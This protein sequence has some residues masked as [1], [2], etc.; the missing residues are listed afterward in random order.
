LEH[1]FDLMTPAD[2]ILRRQCIVFLHTKLKVLL[3]DD[4]NKEIEEIIVQSCKKVFCCLFI[5]SY[6][7]FM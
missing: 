5:H 3:S 6:R 7:T 1:I 2:E 4:N